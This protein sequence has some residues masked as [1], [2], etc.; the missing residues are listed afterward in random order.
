MT[1]PVVP[2]VNVTCEHCEKVFEVRATAK[3]RRFC[4]IPCRDAFYNTHPH[5]NLG[6][7]QKP[8]NKAPRACKQCGK[9][10][11]VIR[12]RNVSNRSGKQFCSRECHFDW[13]KTHPTTLGVYPDAEWRKHQSEAQKRRFMEN[14]ESHVNIIKKIKGRNTKCEQEVKRLLDN[15]GIKYQTQHYLNHHFLDFYIPSKNLAIEVDGCYWHQNQAKDV[16]RDK[17]IIEASPGLRIVHIH[18]NERAY[19]TPLERSPAPNVTYLPYYI[20]RSDVGVL[21]AL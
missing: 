9:E 13:R 21:E 18:F 19:N 8:E 3:P 1:G 2:R 6:R 5:F 14:P 20:K 15:L 16:A 11:T 17:E 12:R 4:S 7:N 10:Y